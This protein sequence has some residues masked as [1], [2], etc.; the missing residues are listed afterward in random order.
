APSLLPLTFQGRLRD[1]LGTPTMPGTAS[2]ALP[3]GPLPSS[4]IRTRA[5]VQHPVETSG[6]ARV[7]VLSPSTHLGRS[8]DLTPTISVDVTAK[9]VLLAARSPFT[10]LR[11]WGQDVTPTGHN[12]LPLLTTTF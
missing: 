10:M 11:T 8:W 2:C 3:A 5:V 4:T 12:A 7:G 9:C 6:T 1:S